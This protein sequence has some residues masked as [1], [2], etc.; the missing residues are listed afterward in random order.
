M[1]K[2]DLQRQLKRFDLPERGRDS[3]VK[4]QLVEGIAR[5]IQQTK[6]GLEF[7]K[8]EEHAESSD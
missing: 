7:L 3:M 4:K 5:G 6:T 8:G 2:E 1:S